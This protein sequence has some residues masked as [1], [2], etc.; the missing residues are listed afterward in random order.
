MTHPVTPPDGANRPS[1][2]RSVLGPD[3]ASTDDFGRPVDR[4]RPGTNPDSTTT[5]DLGR[6]VDRGRPV[7]EAR[8]GIDRDTVGS[9]RVDEPLIGKDD[10]SPSLTTPAT[11]T[12]AG[13]RV[14]VFDRASSG[15]PAAGTV[16]RDQGR[17][18]VLRV[19]DRDRDGGAADRAADRRRGGR[20]GW[21]P[22]PRDR[23]PGRAGI[24]ERHRHR[25]DRGPGRRRSPCSWC[26]W[27]PT[28]AAGTSP[29]GWPGSTAPNRAWRCGCGAW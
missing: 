25:A 2:G 12:T 21:P 23:G 4:A 5:A 1:N 20:S 8:L 29:A 24:A 26:C 16:R 18:G 11:S 7:D 28:T 27:S 6:P 3:P 15:G 22:T 9:T 13:T 14:P 10:R 19:A 17:V